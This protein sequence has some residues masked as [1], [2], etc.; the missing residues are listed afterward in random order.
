[1]AQDPTVI[2]FRFGYGLPTPEGALQAAK[3]TLAALALPDAVAARHPGM[4]L[5]VALPLLREIGATR[6]A[7]KDDPAKKPQYRDA[8]RDGGAYRPPVGRAF[9]I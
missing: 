8:V 6:K 9:R 4:G 3:A 2:A 7:Q 1:M 5:A